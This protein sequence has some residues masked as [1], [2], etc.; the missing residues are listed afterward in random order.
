MAAQ[1]RR[2][3]RIVNRV[4]A[5]RAFDPPCGPAKI[6]SSNVGGVAQLGERIH[7]MDEVRGS[8]PLA[9]IARRALEPRPP[10]DAGAVYFAPCNA[11]LSSLTCLD[12]RVP[13]RAAQRPADR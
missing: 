12:G 8:S 3:V 1:H 5:Y 7:G 11:C 6:V 2:S 4:G 9:S 10:H 13:R